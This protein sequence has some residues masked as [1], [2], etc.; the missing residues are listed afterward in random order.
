MKTAS[1]SDYRCSF[2]VMIFVLISNFSNAQLVSHYNPRLTHSELSKELIEGLESQFEQENKIMSGNREVRQINFDRK[3]LFME[4]VLDGAFIKDDSL[5][6]YVSNILSKI[7]DQNA[8]QSY[9]RRVLILS[10]PH[11]NAVCYGQGIYAVTVGLLARIENENQLA[12]ILAHELAHDELGHIRTRIVQ[13]ADLDLED[14]AREQTIRIISGRIVKNEIDEFRRLIYDYSKDS[15]NNELR[16]DSMA[17]ILLRNARY[18]EREA[19]AALSILQRAQSPKYE[20]GA[21]LF[22]PFHFK[23]YPFQDY[24]LNDRLTVYSK[25]YMGTFLYSA[26]SIETHPTIDSRK[27]ILTTYLINQHGNAINQSVEFVNAVS[28]IAAF[29]TVE[30]AYKNKEYDLSLYHALQLYNR[31]P[32]NAYVISRIGKILAD[33][34]EAKGANRFE[35][36]VAR[37]TPNYCEELKLINSFLYNLT[38]KELGQIA[39][40]FINSHSNFNPAEK[41][42]YYLLW[43][44]TS[45]TSMNE[46]IAQTSQAYKARFGT[47]IGSYKYQ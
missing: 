31:Y 42:H 34:Y 1:M 38:Q 30:S 12:F 26:D 39:F 2:L 44:I 8:L 45:L 13:E 20:I 24:W 40:N 4:K 46:L 14:K 21:E 18:D 27:N 43:K 33:L 7:V 9:P 19:S 6:T 29:E 23:N 11:V 17:L 37:F 3:M 35:D 5:E 15:R 32:E 36:Y 10:S 41:S 28:E 22:L 25:K 47:S 16:A